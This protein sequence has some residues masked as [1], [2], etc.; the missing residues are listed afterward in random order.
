MTKEDI[1]KVNDRL[2]RNDKKK[3]AEL[4]NLHPVTITR[5]F[6]GNKDVVSDETALKILSNAEKVIR[7]RE[8]ISKRSQK[9]LNR[10]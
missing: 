8:K 7:E 2:R 3:I 1:K 9:I 5:F 6:R 10:L 4:S